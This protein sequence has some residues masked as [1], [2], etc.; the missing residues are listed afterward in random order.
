MAPDAIKAITPIKRE[1]I[2][3]F[4]ANSPR[5]SFP[6]PTPNLLI[7]VEAAEVVAEGVVGLF[8]ALN[9]HHRNRKEKLR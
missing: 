7:Q 1:I 5:P 2:L 4:I 9:L 8:Q 6:D 3:V